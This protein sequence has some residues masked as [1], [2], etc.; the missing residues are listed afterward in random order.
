MTHPSAPHDPTPTGRLKAYTVIG[1]IDNEDDSRTLYVAAILTGAHTPAGTISPDNDYTR[2]I[3]VVEATDP[4]H[5][6]ELAA[7]AWRVK[8]EEELQAER[9][10]FAASGFGGADD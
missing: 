5:A 9:E 2:W 1:L 3:S 6:K 7:A 8:A 4:D 10:A